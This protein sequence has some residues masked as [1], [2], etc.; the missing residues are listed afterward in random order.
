MWSPGSSRTSWDDQW[1]FLLVSKT[2]SSF[3]LNSLLHVERVLRLSW[4]SSRPERHN[5]GLAPFHIAPFFNWP[6]LALLISPI[7]L[8]S[9][10]SFIC[11]FFFPL[12]SSLFPYLASHRT[13]LG[14]C[15]TPVVVF[16]SK[17]LPELVPGR[18]RAD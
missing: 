9:C 17:Q 11:Y 3:K 13:F 10:I 7:F 2:E 4:E 6:S 16:R 18:K 5:D 12:I 1:A 15:L 8:S 14:R